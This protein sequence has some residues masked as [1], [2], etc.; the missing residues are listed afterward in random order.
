[1]VEGYLIRLNKTSTLSFLRVFVAL[2]MGLFIANG[3]GLQWLLT[4]V[5]SN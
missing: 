1:M 3:L 2:F 4:A 5:V